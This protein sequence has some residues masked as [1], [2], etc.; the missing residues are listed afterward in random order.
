ME[1]RKLPGPDELSRFIAIQRS[2]NFPLTVGDGTVYRVPHGWSLAVLIEDP[3]VTK[4][5]TQSELEKFLSDPS[6]NS[7]LLVNNQMSEASIGY[8]LRMGSLS[9]NKTVFADRLGDKVLPADGN[10]SAD[11]CYRYSE[12]WA[13]RV[14]QWSVD[15]LNADRLPS[16]I[17]V[18]AVAHPSIAK[19][20]A[21]LYDRIYVPTTW[22]NLEHDNAWD[23]LPP[24]ELTFGSSDDVMATS[25]WG[26]LSDEKRIHFISRKIAEHYQSL[27]Y[28][29]VPG[30][31]SPSGLESGMST[32]QSAAYL[33]AFANIPVVHDSEV[34]WEQVLE[35]REDQE[36]KLS[37][38][39]FREWLRYSINSQSVDE[40]QERIGI[41]LERYTQAIKK[42]GIKTVLGKIGQI[43]DSQTTLLT[44]VTGVAVSI[45][46]G[47]IWP[48]IAA[49]L[50]IAGRAAI[51]VKQMNIENTSFKQS[52]PGR[53]VAYLYEV[54]KEF[55]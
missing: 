51:E 22:G 9:Q 16:K 5:H 8:A 33:A 17:E 1:K 52:A 49:G 13:E 21:L 54:Q 45:A 36:S 28:Q 18:C 29:V 53:E 19:S 25:I 40:A 32:G 7:G 3:V 14:R 55:P 30:Y 50:T 10:P 31:H 39:E 35:F 37:H 2:L 15:S 48:A 46:A 11:E 44:A 42:H 20:A 24:P 6:R 23:E 27:G 26:Y 41:R 12:E 38:R 34:S 47:A 4:I 43:W